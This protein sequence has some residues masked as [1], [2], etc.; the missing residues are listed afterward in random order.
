MATTI[1]DETYLDDAEVAAR[2]LTSVRTLARWRVLGK[3]P[4]H[5]RFGRRIL[6]SESALLKFA[7]D[8]EMRS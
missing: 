4:R 3:A 2:L 5:T 7:H 6:T 1:K 8:N